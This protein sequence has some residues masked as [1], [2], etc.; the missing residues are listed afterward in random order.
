M[1]KQIELKNSLKFEII[2]FITSIILTLV[3]FIYNSSYKHL[4]LI[5]MLIFL[6]IKISL[7]L[8]NNKA[9]NTKNIRLLESIKKYNKIINRI[10]AACVMIFIISILA[11]IFNTVNVK[12]KKNLEA[13]GISIV[14]IALA[15]IS[16][17]LS[18]KI[19][20]KYIFK[21]DIH[22]TPEKYPFFILLSIIIGFVIF[23][24]LGMLILF[25]LSYLGIKIFQ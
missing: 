6:G 13:L 8:L 5:F 15:V 10:F 4:M 25:S 22:K 23:L 1:N 18:R 21:Q 16:A 9:E 17:L 14:I 11:S 19:L 24:I 2:F 3:N 7:Y 12:D 20:I